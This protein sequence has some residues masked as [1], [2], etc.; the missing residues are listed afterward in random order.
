MKYL[1]FILFLL[2]L[3]LHAQTSEQGDTVPDIQAAI[4]AAGEGN[5]DAQCF[6][7][8][9]YSVGQ[10]GVKQDYAEAIKWFTMAAEKG[11]PTAQYNL[12]L[13]YIEG[14]GV[15]PD[16][17]Q[18]QKWYD[19]AKKQRNDLPPLI[20]EKPATND[21]TFNLPSSKKKGKKGEKLTSKDQVKYAEAIKKYLP[22]AEA[23]DAIA[24]YNLGVL[25]A[26]GL[27]TPV[28]NQ[29]AMKWFLMA[30][31]QGD[32]DAQNNIGIM[33]YE[34]RGV[35]K[36]YSQALH[37]YTLAAE[38]EHIAAQYNIG[39]MYERGIGVEKDSTKAKLWFQR[40]ADQGFEPA[41]KRLQKL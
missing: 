15:K 30:A 1:L 40:A 28:N 14:F 11:E 2:P 10:Y 38:Q 22:R 37:W 36:D 18:A 41:K 35:T 23:G 32:A 21:I 5:I 4:Q 3:T 7:G 6:L 9:V 26:A 20:I 34:G 19:L 12:S 24:Q 17:V 33:Y 31:E 29:E 27:G 13:F 8:I 16:T 39:I 25:Y